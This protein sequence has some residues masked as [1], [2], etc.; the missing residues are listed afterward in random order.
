[1]LEL[2][3]SFTK[4]AF[5]D[6]TPFPMEPFPLSLAQRGLLNRISTQGDYSVFSTSITGYYN[7]QRLGHSW[8]KQVFSK[9]LEGI[10]PHPLLKDPSKKK[11]LNILKKTLK[12]IIIYQK[13]STVF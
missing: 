11:N 4:S 8:P 9:S 2:I 6:I 12:K 1:M 13:F 3:F 7:L 10:L 5:D